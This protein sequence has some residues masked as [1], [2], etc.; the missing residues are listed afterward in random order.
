[1][2]IVFITVYYSSLW[3]MQ[4]VAANGSKVTHQRFNHWDCIPRRL[5]ALFEFNIMCSHTLSSTSNGAMCDGLAMAQGQ[6]AIMQGERDGWFTF[7]ACYSSN[8]LHES[9]GENG[10]KGGSCGN[11]DYCSLP[12]SV[13]CWLL[14]KSQC[15]VLYVAS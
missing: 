2:S 14:Q 8:L 1:M 7:I 12:L 15:T 5:G 4:T 6:G 3:S 10:K 9:E 13:Y 11:S